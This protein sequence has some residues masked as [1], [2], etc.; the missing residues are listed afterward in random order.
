VSL[1]I[2]WCKHCGKPHKLGS[3]RCPTTGQ[4][5]EASVARPTVQQRRKLLG[6]TIGGRYKIT[7]RLGS[8]GVAEVFD[9]ENLTLRRR[10]AIK[11]V[12]P[13]STE[14]AARLE[15][16]A[17]AI[18]AIHHPNICDVYDVGRLADGSPYL[19]LE[20]L[21][22]ETLESHLKG[23]ANLRVTPEAAVAVFSQVLSG[24]HGAHDAEILH[25]DLKPA[26]IFLVDRVGCDPLVKLLDFG[27]A[28]DT[29]GEWSKLTRPGRTCGTPQYMSPEQLRAQ[30]LDVRSDLF[31]I[32]V[33]LYEALAGRH[34]FASSN[35]TEVG[36][37]ITREPH[38]RLRDV[39]P[40]AL[41]AVVDRALEK[42]PAKR[43]PSALAMQRALLGSVDRQAVADRTA[44][45]SASRGV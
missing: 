31:S 19:V 28:K 45:A 15:R 18:A 20:F 22:G 37:R 35:L 34:P 40:P 39:C 11:I 2:L 32:G 9:A 25:R 1:G 33:I 4:T 3:D 27:F 6:A 44:P 10:V 14:A 36:I 16:E 38:D 5:I 42:E 12:F 43:F 17:N 24:L 29:S 7:G 30:E 23:R 41:A 26:N 8:G 21:A 13:G